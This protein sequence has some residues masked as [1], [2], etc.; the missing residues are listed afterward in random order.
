MEKLDLFGESWAKISFGDIDIDQHYEVSNYGRVKSFQKDSRNGEIIQG[1]LVQ[2][3][4]TLNLKIS[5]KSSTQ[6]IHKLIADNFVPRP[7]S[8]H[9][10][11]IHLDFDKVNNHFEN[12]KWVTKS[13]MIEHVKINP[14]ITGSR[15]TNGVRRKNYKLTEAKVRIIKIMLRND[16]NR[17]SMIAKQFGITNTQL[18]RIRSGENWGHVKIN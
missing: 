9:R 2:G 8:E 10:Y 6:Y 5:R 12:L 4:R 11:V 15:P 16:K 13:E 1:S 18:N 17:L 7:S 3:Y 14:N